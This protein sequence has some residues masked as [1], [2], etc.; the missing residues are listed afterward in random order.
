MEIRKRKKYGHLSLLAAVS[1]ALCV[2]LMGTGVSYAADGNE[3]YVAG[4]PDSWPFE[5]YDAK[6]ESYEGILTDVLAQ[7][8]E[9]AGLTIHYVNPGKKDERFDMARKAQV[10]AVWTLGMKDKALSQAELQTGE[11]LFTFPENEETVSVRLAYTKAM[12]GE[13][14]EKLEKALQNLN[15]EELNGLLIQYVLDEK[16]ENYI[17]AEVRFA[18]WA[19]FI[20][21]LAAIVILPVKL[22]RKR[23][24]IEVLAYRD[25]ITGK[26]NF[27]VWKQKFSDRITDTNREHYAVFYL[28]AGLDEIS[29]IYGYEEVEKALKLISGACLPL[30]GS[31]EAFARFNDFYF[32]FLVQYTSV[33]RLKERVQAIHDAVTELFKQEKKRYFLELNTGIYRLSHPGEE[34]FETIQYSAVAM[35]YAQN[36]YLNYA[37]YDEFV[38]KETIQGYTMEHEAIYGLMNQ[39]FIMY[40]QPIVNLAD[41]SICGA[42]ALVRWQNPSRGLLRPDT[43]MKA[44]KKKRLTGQ[45]NMEIYRQGCRFL[46]E[47]AALGRKLRLMFNFTVENIG[48]SQFVRHLEAVAAQYEIDRSQVIIQL[49][50]VVEISK[51]EQ[52]IDTIRALRH[53]G[54]TVC[55]AG[56]ELDRVFFDYL[57]AGI[58]GIKLRHELV[59]QVGKPEGRKVL[60]SI[61]HLFQGLGLEVFCVGIETEKQERFLKENGCTLGSGFYYQYPVSQ[62]VFVDLLN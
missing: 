30:M 41:G 35:E 28:N 62:E 42:E 37:L 36:H 11:T 2:L 34:A 50:Q 59:S 22:F 15:H 19:V 25:D 26:E 4:I 44:M 8:A 9:E 24:Q 12:S 39:E 49:N 38:E 52:F 3:I 33:E 17:S 55:M 27:A 40:L 20:A 58:N 54:F 29:R 16:K 47:Q 6:T 32:V 14:R 53:L 13:D 46:M 31:E 61:I 57:D 45:M 21:A 60:E 10:D 48:D 7:A 18:V 43:F 1:F 56:L 5:Q 23:K 51:S